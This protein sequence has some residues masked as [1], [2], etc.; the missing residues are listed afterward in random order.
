MMYD[1]VA[2]KESTPEDSCCFG[3]IGLIR[4][5]ISNYHVGVLVLQD[6]VIHGVI[7]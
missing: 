4:V 6:Q 2:L 5:A 1:L 7:A 3:Y